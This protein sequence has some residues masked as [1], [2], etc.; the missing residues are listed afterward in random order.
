MESAPFG[1]WFG[2][3]RLHIFELNLPKFNFHAQWILEYSTV[4]M[5]KGN[6]IVDIVR[7]TLPLPNRTAIDPP[8]T[9]P[10]SLHLCILVLSSRSHATLTLFLAQCHKSINPETLDPNPHHP[11]SH[12]PH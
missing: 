12:Y 10:L 1:R 11:K 7:A 4:S 8:G 5:H 2:G 3:A 6:T 9:C